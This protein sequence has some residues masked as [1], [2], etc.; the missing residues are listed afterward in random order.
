LAYLLSGLV[1]AV[2]SLRGV[3][4]HTQFT[5]VEQAVQQLSLYGAVS[6]VFFG[7]LYFAVPRLVGKSWSSSF[8]AGGHASL[9]TVGVVLLVVALTAAGFAQNQT[10]F[11]ATQPAKFADVASATRPWLLVAT[12]AQVALLLGNLMLLVNFAQTVAALVPFRAAVNPVSRPALKSV[13]S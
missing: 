4:L 7:A 9:V 13:L 6:M 11:G 12:A 3:A 1:E 5:F 8:L 2:I 10:M